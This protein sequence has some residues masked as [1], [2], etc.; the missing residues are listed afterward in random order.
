MT[1]FP[2]TLT[3]GISPSSD[4]VNSLLFNFRGFRWYQETVKLRAQ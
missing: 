4:T 3:V 2:A 1:F